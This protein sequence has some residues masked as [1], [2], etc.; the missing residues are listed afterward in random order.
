[1]WKSLFIICVLLFTQSCTMALDE[2]QIA[3]EQSI[4]NRIDDV[5]A[6]LLNA[7]KI[8]NRVVFV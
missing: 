5:G 6:K 7:N 4:Q 8:E 2:A 3:K 1:M